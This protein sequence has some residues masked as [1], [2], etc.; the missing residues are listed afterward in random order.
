MVL[1]IKKVKEEAQKEH[2]QEQEARAKERLKLKLQELDKARKVVKNIE[3]E[4]G[5]LEDELSQD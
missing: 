2:Q 4:I 3:R 5:D 1:D